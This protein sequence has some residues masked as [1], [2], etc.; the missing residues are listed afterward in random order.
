MK[1]WPL[2]SLI[3]AI[4]HL[5]FAIYVYNKSPNKKLALIFSLFALSLSL[6][7]FSEFG[8]RISENSSV[9]ATWMKIGGLGWCF[10]P[11]LCC[12]FVIRFSAKRK[13]INN[14][15]TYIGLYLPPAII[16]YLF[17]TTDLI[18]IREPVR[19]YFGYTAIPGKMV[20]L[21]AGY[22]MILY[23]FIFYLLFEVISRGA[24]LKRK[25]AIPILLGS[26]FYILL[27]TT[28]NII[29][30]E[31]SILIP[32]LGTF[33]S[34]IWAASVYYSIH[35]YKLFEMEPS[36][37]N[38]SEAPR[39]YELNEGEI[40]YILQNEEKVYNIF[41]DQAVHGFHGLCITK[42]SP[43][44]IMDKYKFSKTP[45]IQ[46]AFDN[47]ENTISPSD[48]TGLHSVILDFIKKADK[49]CIIIDCLREIRIVN[50]TRKSIDFLTQIGR[51]CRESKAIV[52]ISAD[53][54]LLEEEKIEE[55][56]II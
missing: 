55:L 25:Q 39:K 21:Y 49:A 23:L 8:H 33:F 46:L 3:P 7:S 2:I 35:R 38:H 15:F 40:Y 32:E 45:I 9:A 24:S 54:K 22:Y 16:F 52:L 29:L 47:K 10:M 19:K 18:Y 56:N 17:L 26:G 37:E 44:K 34:I 31:S 4:I 50:G 30:P 20:W 6:W 5:L 48:I 28:T 53:S 42:Y 11:S 12:H 1:I 36:L 13:L 27:S 43:E 41:Y 51:A 14:I